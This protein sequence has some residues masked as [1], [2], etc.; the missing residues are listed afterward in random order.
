MTHATVM[1]SNP[2]ATIKSDL[3][4]RRHRAVA[5]YEWHY[6]YPRSQLVAGGMAFALVYP[7][8]RRGRPAAALAA[9]AEGVRAISGGFDHSH[10][11]R[12]GS[13]SYSRAAYAKSIPAPDTD[14]EAGPDG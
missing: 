12:P 10:P 2:V 3:E 8:E 9:A 5:R 4:P 7:F 1:K 13:G 11:W 14:A 6:S